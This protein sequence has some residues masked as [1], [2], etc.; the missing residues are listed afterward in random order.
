MNTRQKETRQE[1]TL[2]EK[3]G[4]RGE[5]GLQ[6]PKCINLRGFRISSD[7]EVISQIVD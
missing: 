5:L 7:F 2:R 1:L 3:G 6:H 4:G